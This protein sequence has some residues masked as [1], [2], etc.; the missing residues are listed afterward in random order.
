M[1]AKNKWHSQN[2]NFTI[3]MLT[4]CQQDDKAAWQHEEDIGSRLA[5]PSALHDMHGLSSG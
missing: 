5:P 1:L 4:C 3:T 2:S